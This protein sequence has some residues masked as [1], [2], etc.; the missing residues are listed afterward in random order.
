MEKEDIWVSPHGLVQVSGD[1]IEKI[2]SFPTKRKVEHCNSAFEV[3]PL[4]I[5]GI[6]P[7]CNITIKLRS[8]AGSYEL[9]DVFDTIFEWLLQPEAQEV[10]TKRQKEIIDDLDDEE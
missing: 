2:K 10:F 1:L 3:S 4:D 5:Y 8:Y 6:C 9:Q 7:K